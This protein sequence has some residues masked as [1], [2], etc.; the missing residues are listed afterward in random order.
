MNKLAVDIVVLG[1]GFAGSLTA[2]IL[3]QIGR[4]VALIDKA[5]HPRF[6]IGESSTPIA[7]MVL[8]DLAVRYDLPQLLPLCKFGTWQATHPEVTCGIK[9]GFSYFAHEANRPFLPTASHEN[10]LLVAASADDEH[11]D[12]Q[13]L[14]ADVDAFLYRKAE[15]VGVEVLEQTDVRSLQHESGSGWRIECERDS[16]RLVVQAN[17]VIDATGEAGIVPQTLEIE[18][19]VDRTTTR[20]RAIFSHF[21]GVSDWGDH[22][23]GLGGDTQHHPFPCDHAAQHHLLDGAWMWMLRFQQSHLARRADPTHQSS[24]RGARRL[25]CSIG[26][27]LDATMHPMDTTATAAA[28]W[29]AWLD[30][31]P[32]ISHMLAETKL[33]DQPG[34]IVRTGLLQRRWTQLVG[35]DWAL[36]PHTAGFVDPL[37]STGIAHSLCGVERLAQILDQS[38]GSENLPAELLEY[39][40]VL[41]AELDLI[42]EL[43]SGCFE[44]LGSFDMFATYSMLYFAAA[45]SYE[46]RRVDGAHPER[47]AFLCANDTQFRSAVQVA[48]ER[49][50][51]APASEQFFDEVAELIAPFN[52]V[53][54]C[55]RSVRNMYR[56]TVAPM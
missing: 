28:E 30:R 8:R 48:R 1:S 6:A 37:H 12:T 18:S 33:A 32:S 52:R 36:L 2:M 34:R 27:V 54:L 3:R 38:W 21:V 31:Y 15:A 35:R 51:S 44:T 43:V 45:T 23:V 14:R 11:S 46:H 40:K 7:N 41:H 53:G 55:D 4:S 39:E 5:K 17:F 24:S 13:W 10:E 16:Q 42:D 50:A 56:Y 9:R 19:D 22:F 20:S 29:Q 47:L 26:L 25:L 49:L